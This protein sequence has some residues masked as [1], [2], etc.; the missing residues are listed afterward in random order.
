MD[1]IYILTR[2]FKL[3]KRCQ[4]IHRGYIIFF[5]TN[6][7]GELSHLKDLSNKANKVLIWRAFYPL[8]DQG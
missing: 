1:C 3:M 4:L 5:L 2:D 6:R 7:M 8:K